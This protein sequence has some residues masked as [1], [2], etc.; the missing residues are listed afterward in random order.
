MIRTDA[1]QSKAEQAI[2]PARPARPV[3]RRQR[4]VPSRPR[5]RRAASPRLELIT[6]GPGG[7]GFGLSGLWRSKARFSAQS[8]LLGGGVSG[9]HPVLSVGI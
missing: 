4:A 1:G 6:R 9:W 5:G 7:C 3:W 8:S 2:S